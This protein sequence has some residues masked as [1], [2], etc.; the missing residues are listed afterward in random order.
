MF[1]SWGC[2]GERLA[3]IEGKQRVSGAHARGDG[4][5]VCAAPVRVLRH[6]LFHHLTQ[7]LLTVFYDLRVVFASK[8]G[9]NGSPACYE[10]RID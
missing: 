4:E 8:P 7:L 5:S 1:Q 10:G 6:S 9:T 3:L 2:D